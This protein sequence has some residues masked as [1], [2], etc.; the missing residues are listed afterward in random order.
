MEE[1]GLVQFEQRRADLGGGNA[2]GGQE[3]KEQIVS[4]ANATALLPPTARA[5]ATGFR[6]RRKFLE[7]SGIWSNFVLRV[8][9]DLKSGGPGFRPTQH[10]Y[11]SRV[12]PESHGS[13][14][15]APLIR[16]QRCYGEPTGR[17][18]GGSR[19][20]PREW[21]GKVGVWEGQNLICDREPASAKKPCFCLRPE[22]RMG[23]D[24]R[25]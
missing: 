3:Q 25:R 11:R 6:G 18:R 14:P 7:D 16:G 24:F 12:P 20:S 8:R 9:D 10:R 19:A 23:C 15:V 17:L 4:T 22:R 1:R 13:L 2:C 5:K 21:A